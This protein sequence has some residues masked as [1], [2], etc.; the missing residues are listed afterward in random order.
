MWNRPG[1]HH[2]QELSPPTQPAA[3]SRPVQRPIKEKNKLLS[4]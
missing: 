4:L 1:Y 3:E 2:S